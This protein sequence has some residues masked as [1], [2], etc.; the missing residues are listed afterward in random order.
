MLRAIFICTLLL[1]LA[2]GCFGGS[3]PGGVLVIPLTPNAKHQ[4]KTYAEW[5]VEWWKWALGQPVSSN[6]L[7]DTSGVNAANGQHGTVWFLGATF[8]DPPT[9][10]RSISVPEGT[11]LFFPLMN[12][13]E[14]SAFAP[15]M[16]IAEMKDE[17]ATKAGQVSALQLNVDGQDLPDLLLLRA[18]SPAAFSVDLPAGGDDVYMHFGVDAGTRVNTVVSDG[19]WVFIDPLPPGLHQISFG[20]SETEGG[21]TTTVHATYSVIVAAAK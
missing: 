5:S 16:S 1:L 11:A 8:G 18:K 21:A 20:G 15:K 13:E 9:V 7:F 4:G 6:P 19:Y 14:D 10:T 3:A 17:I 12:F 2:T